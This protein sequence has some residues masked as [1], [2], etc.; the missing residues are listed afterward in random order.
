MKSS[1]SFFPIFLIITGATWLSHHMDLLPD[2]AIMVANAFGMAGILVLFFDGINKRS[3]VLG[4]LLMYIG[5]AIYMVHNHFCDKSI[6]IALGMMVWGLL[7]L[8]ARS[9]VIPNKRNRHEKI[10]YPKQEP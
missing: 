4:P 10:I 6:A 9:N 3:I 1:S 5:A 8:I 7:M 2:T